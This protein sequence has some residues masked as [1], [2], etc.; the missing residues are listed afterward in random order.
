MD[1]EVEA[2]LF[3]VEDLRSMTEKFKSDNPKDVYIII[4]KK[5]KWEFNFMTEVETNAKPEIWYKYYNSK[6]YTF[7][8]ACKI[9]KDILD[10]CKAKKVFIHVHPKAKLVDAWGESNE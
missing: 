7:A 1:K 8:I 4:L 10:K 6:D 2:I 5:D 3:N 9:L